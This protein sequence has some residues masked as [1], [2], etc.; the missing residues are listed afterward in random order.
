M[1]EAGHYK[2]QVLDQLAGHGNV[3]Q[4]VSFDPGLRQR[5]SRVRG[6]DANTMFASPLAAVTTLLQA[7]AEASVN[8]RT[9]HPFDPKSRE[10]VYGLKDATIAFERVR[11]LADAGLHTIVNETVDIHDGGVSGVAFGDVVEFAPEDT[12]RCVEK[13]GTA[14][15]ERNLA[16]RLFQTVYGFVP[17]LPADRS[18]RV[19]FSIHPLPR[20]YRGGHSIVWETEAAAYPPTG[21]PAIRWP[22]CFSRFIGDKTFGLVIASLLGLKVP[23][24]LVIPRRLA[25]FTFGDGGSPEPW[26]RTA[27]TEQ[28]PGRFTTRRGWTDP[29]ALLQQ[30]DPDGTM[31]AAVLRQ[32]GISAVAS[33]AAVEQSDGSLLIEGVSGFGDQFM[34]GERKPES[35]APSTR[36]R[37]RDIY[38]RIVDAIGPARFEWVD[39]GQA[40]W[41]V[42]L[43]SGA[44]VS[45]GSTIV[46]GSPASFRRFAVEDGLERLRSLIDEVKQTGD[47][48]ALVGVVGIT[49]H[50]GDVLRRS[51]IPSRL[52]SP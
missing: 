29:F 34:V 28:A 7:S 6:F 14:A 13:P 22:N 46:P 2:D 4:F 31:I 43:H 36:D 16:F 37:V 30:E 15:L 19:E 26:I 52:E 39:D 21:A 8:I 27:P 25:P 50:F 35:L 23:R 17:E 40:V 42:Q 5:F 38:Q 1:S 44:S 49:S 41:V 9:F 48:I 24:T 47:G 18:L 32:N 11:A 33:G 51:G 45:Q 20:G 3:A 12:P 10:F